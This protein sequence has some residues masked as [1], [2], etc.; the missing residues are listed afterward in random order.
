LGQLFKIAHEFQNLSRATIDKQ[1]GS[2][3]P[4]AWTTT[5]II[6][7]HMVVIQ[8]H[9]GKNTIEDVLLDGGSRINII[10]KQLRLRLGLPKPKP[11][12]YNLKM[13]N[14]ST[15]ILMGLIRDLKIYVHGIPYITTFIVL[16]KNVV[17]FNYSML[18]RRQW[19]KD[20]KV[21]HD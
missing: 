6:D 7:N 14:Q 21:A 19:L 12:P 3:I 20:A 17:D 5:V 4:K 15:I 2:S 11:A 13:A 8:V 10:T 16:H 18:L 9:I 1:V